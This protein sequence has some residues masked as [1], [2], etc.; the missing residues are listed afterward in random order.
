[1]NRTT[2][3]IAIVVIVL[4]PALLAE[5]I[6]ER[7]LAQLK[8]QHEKAVAVA[9]EPLKRRY[10]TSL[11][12][13]L[14]RATLAKDLDAAIKI[15]DQ[16]RALGIPAGAV[17]TRRFFLGSPWVAPSGTSFTF[18]SNGT[19]IRTLGGRIIPFNWTMDPDGVVETTCSEGTDYFHFKSRT[20]GEMSKQIDGERRPLT[21][22]D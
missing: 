9:I 4:S 22:K 14:Q 15:R 18:K 7:E 5:S 21:R 20:K 2:L 8:D 1:M 19:G 3:A 12:Q 11:E 16:L 10:Q 13:L 17:D 6:C